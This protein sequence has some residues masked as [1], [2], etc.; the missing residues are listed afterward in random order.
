MTDLLQALA[1][2]EEVHK[3]KKME[4]VQRIVDAVPD[5]CKPLA[6]LHDTIECGLDWDDPG[7]IALKLSSEELEAL[8]LVS[9]L[10]DE[11]YAEYI[12]GIA[13]SPN[14]MARIVKIADT[15]DHLQ[16]EDDPRRWAAYEHALERLSQ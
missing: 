9:R 5:D 4:H 1:L 12:G 11:P 3:P 8:D 13:E 2:A 14:D 10:D 7:L 15:L 16:D 6:A